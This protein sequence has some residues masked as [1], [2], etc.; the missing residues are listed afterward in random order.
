MQWVTA[1][2]SPSF[3]CSLRVEKPAKFPFECERGQGFYCI[4]GQTVIVHVRNW[5]CNDEEVQKC[6]RTGHDTGCLTIWALRS[7]WA[8]LVPGLFPR[9][10]AWGEIL[11]MAVAV[12][13]FWLPL[14]RGVD[15]G[16]LDRETWEKLNITFHDNTNK[17]NMISSM[18]SHTHRFLALLWRWS[19]VGSLT[20]RKRR[21]Q[22]VPRQIDLEEE[23]EVL[24]W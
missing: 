22:S 20:W 2:P 14:T 1:H 8:W 21:C 6:C 19:L 3:L 11:R 17:T 12:L 15:P 16:V 24:W 18:L 9:S 23:I 13:R 7:I 10:S 4:V 5:N